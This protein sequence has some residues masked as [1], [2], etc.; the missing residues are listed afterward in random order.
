MMKCNDCIHVKV[1]RMSNIQALAIYG[2]CCHPSLEE[3][4]L[5]GRDLDVDTVWF[6]PLKRDENFRETEG[7][8]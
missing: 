6:C 2:F 3:E 4:K 7:M 5:I 1:E 8:D